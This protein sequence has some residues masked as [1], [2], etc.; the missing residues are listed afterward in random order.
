MRYGRSGSCP[1]RSW[2]GLLARDARV[3]QRQV[4]ALP[5]PPMLGVSTTTGNP[6]RQHL[7][8][9]A[10][11]AALA[12]CQQHTDAPTTP[13]ATPQ[14][15]AG[16]ADPAADSAFAALSKRAVD[17]WM[18]LSPVGATQTGDHRYDSELDDL[19]AAGRQKSLDASKQLLAELDKLDV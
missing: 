9:A 13:S 4:R 5:R 6:M 8:A 10:L 11:L 7:L 12:G 15:A 17:T 2:N 1:R 18:Q 3:I 19:S 14:A 16:A